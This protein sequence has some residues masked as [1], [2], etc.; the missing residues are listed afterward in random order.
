MSQRRERTDESL[1]EFLVLNWTHLPMQESLA[2]EHSGELFGDALEELLDGRRVADKGGRHLQ[3]ARRNVANRRLMGTGVG[4]RKEG[5]EERKE[6][7]GKEG[8]RCREGREGGEE[9]KKGERS[10][11]GIG[12]NV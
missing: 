4:G 1:D 12:I 3:A 2:P 6:R 10:K 8:A 7:R 11:T 5:R 9:E